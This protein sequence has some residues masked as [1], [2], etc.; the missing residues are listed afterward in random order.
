M[1]GG[2]KIIRRHAGDELAVGFDGRIGICAGE[3]SL[4][5]N[6]PQV[7]LVRIQPRRFKRVGNRHRRIRRRINQVSLNGDLECVQVFR[8]G[9]V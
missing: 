8:P 6:L 3:I 2:N 4:A 9:G 5:R 1:S 7:S